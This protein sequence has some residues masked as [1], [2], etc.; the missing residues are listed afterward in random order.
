[1]VLSD[2]IFTIPPEKIRDVHV[3]KTVLGG[4]VI[5][6]VSATGR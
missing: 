1:V 3:L 5:F 4:R 2:D 6:E